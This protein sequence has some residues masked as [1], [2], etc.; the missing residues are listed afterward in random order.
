MREFIAA[1][2]AAG[3]EPMK[4]PLD[5]V[6]GQLVRFRA[7]GDKPGARNAWAVYHSTPTPHG[8]FGSWRTGVHETWRGR[9]GRAYTAAER[10][11]LRRQEVAQ[12]EQH[13]AEQERVH[14]AGRERARRLW[15]TARPATT[16]HPYLEAKGVAPYGIRRLRDM[17]LVPARDVDGVLH[18]LQFI[19]IDGSKRFL[20]GGRISGCY[21]AIGQ[22][23]EDLY[24]CEGFATGA[25]VYAATAAA[26][27]V[28]FSAGNLKPVALALRAKFPDARLVIAADNDAGTA[29][30]PGVRA[31]CEAAAAVGALVAVPDFS[32]VV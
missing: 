31:A 32:V 22:P 27:A 26:V 5:L 14:A 16:E 20:T 4:P 7:V 13:H 11:E 18:T 30:N 12:R 9:P 25:T 29:G 19:G 10:A 24:L 3:I 6:D 8:A 17:L 2:A 28:C 1:M 23:A 21:C 15:R